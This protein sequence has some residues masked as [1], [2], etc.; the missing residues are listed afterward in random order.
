MRLPLSARTLLALLAIFLLA[1][2]LRGAWIRHTD[3]QLPWLGDPQYYHATAQN[4]AEGR[5]YSVSFEDAGFVADDNSQPT[6]FWAPGFPFALAPF[7]KLFGARIAVGKIFNA[8]VGALAVLPIFY[9]GRRL[10]P[11]P[12]ADP[13]G[14]LAAFLFAITPSLVFWTPAILSEPLFTLG[15][16]STL[17][18]ALWAG[19]RRSI[20][21]FALTGLLLTATAFVRSQGAVLIVPVAILLVRDIGLRSVARVAVPVGLAGAVLLVPRAVRNRLV[22]GH[23]YLINDDLGYN[24]RIAHGPNST[25]TSVP[26]QDL[27]DDRPG[28]SFKEREVFFDEVGGKRAWAYA[29]THV[30]REAALVMYRE[31]Y[32]LRSDAADSLWESLRE[33]PTVGRAR[34]AMFT[35]DVFYYALLALTAASAL[36][37]RRSRLFFALWST[38]GVWLALHLIF[39][40]EPR[41][42]VPLYPVAAV[43]SAGALA[44]IATAVQSRIDAGAPGFEAAAEPAT[45]R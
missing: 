33:R 22:M 1:L 32:L 25:G 36:L 21:G 3:T 10:W 19:E 31:R 9:L 18:V 42:H 26:P 45:A 39:A 43:L 11:R 4:I 37:V 38:I 13:A 35:G 6:D 5:G 16:A 8:I 34:L 23:V 28:I 15:L 30:R 27:W 17:A 44:A 41:Y 20:A 12:H 7:Y 14:L 29:R 2:G 40:G 24:L